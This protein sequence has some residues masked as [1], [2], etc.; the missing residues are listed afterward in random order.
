M[1]L[2][3]QQIPVVKRRR[4]HVDQHLAGPRNGVRYLGECKVPEAELI[5]QNERFHDP[6]SEC[7]DGVQ[8]MQ[9]SAVFG[10]TILRELLEM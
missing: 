1:A 2:S 5:L 4:V 3:D 9:L 6:A 10:K 7:V 8:N